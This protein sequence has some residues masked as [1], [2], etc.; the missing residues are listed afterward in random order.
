MG[1]KLILMRS[2]IAQ[3]ELKIKLKKKE[4]QARVA[5]KSQI[6][7]RIIMAMMMTR[8]ITR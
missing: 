1:Q 4:I 5:I 6:N 3:M 2:R 8:V 7:S